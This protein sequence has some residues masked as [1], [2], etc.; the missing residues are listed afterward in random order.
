M[1]QR[2]SRWIIVF[3][4]IGIMI[5]FVIPYFTLDPDDSRI[6]I[7]STTIQYPALVA[8]IV[9]AL[10]ALIAG[11]FQFSDR[12]RVSQPKIHRYMGRVY[13]VSVLISGVLALVVVSYVENFTKAVSF[14]VLSLLWIFTTWRGYR[15]AV[16]RRFEEHR[17][18]IMRSFGFTLVAVIARLLVPILLLTYY[19]LNGFSLP[20]GREKMVEEVLNV[21]IGVGIIL[22]LVIVEWL[23]LRKKKVEK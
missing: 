23:I 9:F 15:T 18:W 11:F 6:T 4:S 10:I 19:V 14:L 17:Q 8:H 22:N 1:K 7:S 2:K 13:V 16:Q 5:P 12:I 21:N 3:V 20:G